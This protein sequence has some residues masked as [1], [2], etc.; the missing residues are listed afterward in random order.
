MTTVS[1]YFSSSRALRHLS[2]VSGKA[3]SLL[4]AAPKYTIEESS[5]CGGLL[6]PEVEGPARGLI[7]AFMTSSSWNKLHSAPNCFQQFKSERSLRSQWPLSDATLCDF[8]SWAV[9]VRGL[10]TSSVKTYHSNLSTIHELRG[11][12]RVNCFQGLTKRALKGAENIAF[13]KSVVDDSRKVMT[14]PLL[15]L[16]GHEIAHS[17]WSKHNKQVYWTA[18]TTAFFGSFRFGEILAPSEWALTNMKHSFGLMLI[19]AVTQFLSM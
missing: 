1:Q 6:L 8:V 18:C 13:Y 5:A 14:L 15:K 4:H 11:L 19:L 3:P 9:M 12:G 17:S 7:Q 2:P 16:L 10:K